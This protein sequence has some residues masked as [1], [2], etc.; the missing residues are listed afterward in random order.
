M[1]DV[2][3][4]IV[5]GAL[6]RW[7][8]ARGVS[9]DALELK[10]LVPINFRTETDTGTYKNSDSGVVAPLPVYAED[11]GERLRVIT[12]AM[13]RLKTG[14][15]VVGA[16]LLSANFPRTITR[17]ATRLFNLCVTNLPGP[18]VP[19]YVMGR[20]LQALM[21]ILPIG[22]GQALGVAVTSYNG[23]VFFALIAD[24]SNLADLDSLQAHF[25]AS[26]AEY[27]A[28]I[29]REVEAEQ[30]TAF[31]DDLEGAGLKR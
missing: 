21:P 10:V 6:R 25:D 28:I 5:T 24:Q 11:P 20:K 3:L 9:I 14:S 30:E 26:I 16:E 23:D 12:E 22:K 18:Q 7:L 1:N 8:P 31:N 27:A 17:R 15:Q 29:G 2:A 4:A 19:M 13:S